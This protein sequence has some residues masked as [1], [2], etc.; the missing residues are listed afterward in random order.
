VI[1][2][3]LDALRP[4]RLDDLVVDVGDV[5]GIDEA[6]LAVDV[7]EQAR[8]HVEHHRRAGIADMGAIVDGGAADIHRHPLGSAGVETRFSRAIV[9]WRRISVMRVRGLA[10]L[11]GRVLG[12]A[13]APSTKVD[14][15]RP[16]DLSRG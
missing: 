6:V 1:T 8:E 9:S 15:A 14:D 12:T 13:A 2:D 16:L 10:W 4:R 3:G 5:A 7:A 11:P